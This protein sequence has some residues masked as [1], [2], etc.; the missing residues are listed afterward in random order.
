[1]IIFNQGKYRSLHTAQSQEL[2][3][4]ANQVA[5]DKYFRP[6]YHIAPPTGLLNDPNG[7]IFDGENYHIF[8][9]WYPFDAIHG[10]KHWQHLITPDFVNYRYATPLI[11]EELFESHGCYSGG[12]LSYQDNIVLFYTG[13]TRRPSDNDRV[14]YQ[15]IVILNPQGAIIE[16][17]VLIENA[18]SGYTAH[19]RD[20][21]PYYTDDG[22]IRFICGVQRDN[23]S[24]TALIYEMDDPYSSVRLIGEFAITDFDNN[25][26]FMW[27][28]PD[29]LKLNNQ[30]LFIWSPQGKLREPLKYQNNYHALYALGNVQNNTLHTTHY[31]ELDQGFDFYA[32]QTFAGIDDEQSAVMLAWCGL[33]NL[34]YP[35]DQYQWHSMLTLPRQLSIINNKVFQK[36]IPQI[37]LQMNELQHFT[38][39]NTLTIDQLDQRYLCFD[40]INKS[41]SL[42]LFNN[43]CNQHIT[44][45]YEDG[46]FCIDR[47]T[48]EQTESM[49]T[50]GSQRYCHIETLNKLE[51][52]IDHSIIEIYINDGEKVLTSR[53]FISARQSILKTSAPLTFVS[54]VINPINIDR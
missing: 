5:Q 22:K 11:P 45:S 29:L 10:M 41:F 9:Q 16:K 15:N 17:R 20:P 6:Q 34:Q 33:P 23:L 8:Y 43:P 31:D 2:D 39:E 52:F 49:L 12:A 21:K 7:L 18:P 36:P 47:S 37:Y 53:F 32:P 44:L 30:D 28:C 26:V 35:T 50:L 25:N 24:G 13:N 1:M 38:I 27:E 4:I 51:I 3:N 46:V 14:P 42:A 19:F 54:S 40:D 48:S